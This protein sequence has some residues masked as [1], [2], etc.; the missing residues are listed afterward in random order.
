MHG[1]YFRNF[2]CTK[3]PTGDPFGESRTRFVR[4]GLM[5][6]G[7]VFLLFRHCNWY[8]FVFLV[9]SIYVSYL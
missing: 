4:K 3:L 8:G 1:N 7:A 5:G 9:Y 6:H 2:A